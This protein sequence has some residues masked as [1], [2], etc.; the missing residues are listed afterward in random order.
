[1]NPRN[2]HTNEE[3]LLIVVFIL[4]I[5]GILVMLSSCGWMCD[6][7]DASEGAGTVGRSIKDADADKSG[8]LSVLEILS[9]MLGG[10]G[11]LRPTETVARAAIRRIK[12][13]GGDNGSKACASRRKSEAFEECDE[14]DEG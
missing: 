9:W 6:L 8:S 10:W 12:N 1:M 4:A 14:R 2:R 13:A 5:F 3:L 11:V 7:A